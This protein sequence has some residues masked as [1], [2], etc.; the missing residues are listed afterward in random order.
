L[1]RSGVGGRIIKIY[2]ARIRYKNVGTKVGRK[3]TVQINIF[4]HGD[5]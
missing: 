2:L 4:W 5:T 3:M 1:K